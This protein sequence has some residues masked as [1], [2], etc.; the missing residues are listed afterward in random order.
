MPVSSNGQR[1]HWTKSD[2]VRSVCGCGG[3]LSFTFSLCSCG[4]PRQAQ[5]RAPCRGSRAPW[6]AS[7]DH[8]HWACIFLFFGCILIARSRRPPLR[9]TAANG[10]PKSLLIFGHNTRLQTQMCKSFGLP[11]VGSFDSSSGVLSDASSCISLKEDIDR[12]QSELMW[13]AEREELNARLDQVH[14]LLTLVGDKLKL[15]MHTRLL[16]A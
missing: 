12:R 1:A 10:W 8:I 6:A 14:L 15:D 9:M 5:S 7:R 3:V 16:C 13:G 11:R 4:A 2:S